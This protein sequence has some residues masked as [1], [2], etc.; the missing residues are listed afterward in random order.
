MAISMSSVDLFDEAYALDPFP[1]WDALRENAPVHYEPDTGLW[2]VSRYDDVRAVLLDT[3]TFLP[4]N[5]MD[6]IG[7]FSVPTLR[8]L[9]KAKFAL[10]PTLASNGGESHAGYR[11]IM[12]RLLNAQAVTAAVPMVEQVTREC[13]DQVEERLDADGVC[14]LATTLA[15]D[16]PLRVLLR[17]LGLEEA[18][19]V[20][21]DT[22]ARWSDASLELFWGRPDAGRQRELAGEAADFYSWLRSLVTEPRPGEDTL[23]GALAAHRLPGGEPLSVAETAA[24]LYFM[25]IAGQATTRQML[26][27]MYR[28]ALAQPGLWQRFADEPGSAQPWTEEVL[29]REPPITTWRRVTGRPVTLCGVDIPAGAPLLLML[30]STGSD[31]EVFED[32]EQLCPYRPNQRR[33]LAF[34]V[35]RHRC[36]G[37]ELARME[38][39][40]MMRMTAS[41]LPG[42]RL[43]DIS[44]PPEML[45]LLS[46]RA[47]LHVLV[48][49]G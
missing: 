37:A 33:H 1:V 45:G 15:R 48:E 4:D 39:G 8:V 12:T 41:R 35:G 21:I 23:L 19:D 26:S 27:I 28:R 24:V 3:D 25:I 5:A 46:F 40:V 22:L 16:V 18:M 17:L 43:A 29:R 49:R 11:R 32:P 42:L 31:P 14:D 13:L 6:A 10:P 7:R 47:P 9:A 34:G 38:A 20:G 44:S 36:S 2:L 30:A